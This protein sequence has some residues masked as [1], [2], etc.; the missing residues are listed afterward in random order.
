MRELHGGSGNG[1]VGSI[2]YGTY[3]NGVIDLLRDCAWNAGQ[4]HGG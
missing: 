1:S 4:R 2:E 3:D